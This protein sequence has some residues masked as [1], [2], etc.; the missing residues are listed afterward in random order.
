MSD[1]LLQEA[2]TIGQ[3][4]SV[5]QKAQLI[6]WLSSDL[7]QALVEQPET[8]TV[9]TLQPL[10][11]HDLRAS[12]TTDQDPDEVEPTWT[13]AEIRELMKP[14]PKTGAEIVALS[15]TLDLRSWREQEIPDV[16]DLDAGEAESTWTAAAISALMKPDPKTGAE[17]AAMIESGEI[18]PSIG[19][20][21]DMPDV[22]KWLE[23]LRRQERIERGLEA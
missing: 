15:K 4:L 19:A 12:I 5:V 11:G 8:A 20:E 6:E 16:T 1:L 22:V 3:Q 13:A 10:N 9:V 7:H 17:I 21:I 14:E 18:D 23:N 2:R